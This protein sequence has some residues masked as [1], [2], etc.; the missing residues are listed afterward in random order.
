[1]IQAKI[2]TPSG[3]KFSYKM[4]GSRNYWINKNG[5]NHEVFLELGMDSSA[6]RIAHCAKYYHS[7]WKG[8]ASDAWP[9]LRYT[10]TEDERT[11]MMVAAMEGLREYGCIVEI[12]GAKTTPSV[13]LDQFF[14]L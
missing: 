6:A 13:K 11:E 10:H 4:D 14:A 3:K 1:M 8:T 2:K 5:A 9:A 12:T 7:K